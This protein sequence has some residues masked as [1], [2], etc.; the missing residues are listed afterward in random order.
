VNYDF[1]PFIYFEGILFSL[2]RE[3]SAV[4]IV[5]AVDE[6]IENKNR[7]AALLSLDYVPHLS[8]F[9]SRPPGERKWNRNGRSDL[10]QREKAPSERIPPSEGGGADVLEI[11]SGSES[12]HTSCAIHQANSDHANDQP[13]HG[14]RWKER[15]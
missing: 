6:S 13:R 4:H 11:P 9:G 8:D 5:V 2:A 15:K 14:E 10:F 3:K 1:S 7:H 12:A